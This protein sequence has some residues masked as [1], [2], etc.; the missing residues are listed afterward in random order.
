MGKKPIILTHHLATVEL[1]NKLK[2]PTERFLFSRVFRVVLIQISVFFFSFRLSFKALPLRQP[3]F[4][5]S[6]FQLLL[7]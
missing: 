6:G 1:L 3:S 5:A 7:F 2:N 4:L